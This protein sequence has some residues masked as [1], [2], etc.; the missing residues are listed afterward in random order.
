MTEDH[1]VLKDKIVE[2]L[3]LI[4]PVFCTKLLQNLLKGIHKRFH[5]DLIKQLLKTGNPLQWVVEEKIKKI[6]DL[7]LLIT[8]PY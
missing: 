6:H 3:H 4:C 7:R 2:W 8:A 5:L 1:L